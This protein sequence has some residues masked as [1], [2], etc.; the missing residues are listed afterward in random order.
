MVRWSSS[1]SEP[2]RAGGP[3]KGS[4]DLFAHSWIARPGLI[5]GSPWP[6]LAG[7]VLIGIPF[8]ILSAWALAWGQALL[9][10]TGIVLVA[11]LWAALTLL[12]LGRVRMSKKRGI[13]GV[14]PRLQWRGV[15]PG[16]PEL[17]SRRER[18]SKH[19]P[20]ALDTDPSTG[21]TWSDGATAIDPR[22]VLGWGDHLCLDVPGHGWHWLT[23]GLSPEDRAL[24]TWL[25]SRRP[26]GN[27]LR[28]DG[29]VPH[30]GDGA[31][32]AGTAVASCEPWEA[33]VERR[34]QVRKQA[35][36]LSERSGSER[37]VAA[38][39]DNFPPTAIMHKDPGDPLEPSAAH[40]PT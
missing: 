1:A 19:T 17:V 34:K 38:P 28:A 39:A 4:P 31:G 20:A 18:A 25:Y 12:V 24:K 3:A 23:L 22:L 27:R 11:A 32:G 30:V 21:F 16:E 40:G 5:T 7:A 6:R 14:T 33:A 8:V 2:I 10:P 37:D 13:S 26:S 15:W 35:G 29:S 9:G 36:K